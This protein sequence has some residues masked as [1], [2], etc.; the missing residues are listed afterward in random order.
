VRLYEFA[1]DNTL[2]TKLTAIVSQIHGRV[3]DTGTKKP[4]SLKSLLN[5]LSKNGITVSSEQ[6][7]E[8]VKNPPLEN[9]ISN[10][11]GDDV[12][13]R[14][15]GHNASS[16]SEAEEPEQSTKTLKRMA[17]RAEKKRET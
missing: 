3:D 7:K 14:G 12:I 15:H 11:K 8:M 16:D 10:V 17:R 2:P 13:F 5:V 6:F 9:L 4:Y 1:E